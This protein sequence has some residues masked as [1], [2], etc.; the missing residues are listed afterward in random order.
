MA[1]VLDLMRMEVFSYQMV[2][3]FVNII[4]GA[5]ISSLVHIGN[6]RKD[7]LIFDKGCN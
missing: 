6:K 2:V 7:I 1:M 5:D 4:F 3:A